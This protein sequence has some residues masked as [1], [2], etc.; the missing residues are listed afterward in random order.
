M[1][2]KIIAFLGALLCLNGS[3]LLAQNY[4]N[5]YNY[6]MINTANLDNVLNLTPATPSTTDIET[7]HIYT[8]LNASKSLYDHYMNLSATVNPATNTYPSYQYPA[9]NASQ[10]YVRNGLRFYKTTY[11]G[12]HLSPTQPDGNFRMIIIRPN[13]DSVRRCILYTNGALDYLNTSTYLIYPKL[14]DL[15]LRGYVVVFY[16]NNG[17][18]DFKGVGGKYYSNTA[19]YPCYMDNTC[20]NIFPPIFSGDDIVRKNY[21][22]SFQQGV[23]AYN[24]VKRAGNPYS[25]DTNQVFTYG[26]SAGAIT[27]LLLSYSRPGINFQSTIYVDFK[28]AGVRTLT[29]NG[30]QKISLFNSTA[31]YNVFIRTTAQVATAFPNDAGAGNFFPATGGRQVPALLFHGVNDNI[32]NMNGLIND[33]NNIT[34]GAIQ[35]KTGLTSGNIRSQIVVNCSGEH[36]F[37]T[38]PDVVI[39]NSTYSSDIDV[40]TQNTLSVKY[41]RM[42]YLLQQ[43]ND[44][45]YYVCGSFN[46]SSINPFPLPYTQLQNQFF[47]PTSSPY[48]ANSTVNNGHFTTSSCNDGGVTAN[49]PFRVAEPAN[50]SDILI[51]NNNNLNIFPNPGMH[52]LRTTYF[53]PFETDINI[54]IYNSMGAEVY[55]KQ[56]QHQIG[57]VEYT[58]DV[59]SFA[60]GAYFMILS[61][62]NETLSK[63]ITVAH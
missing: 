10:F 18:Q 25:I 23:A 53:T 54:K 33:P 5:G 44:L 57:R 45:N 62:K 34:D 21:Y 27:S 42:R 17:S 22:Y 46:F 39:P 19:A 38:N 14:I 41:Y 49:N 31:P 55:N 50:E 63:K 36:Y 15:A 16:E 59:S 51:E 28:N 6:Y 29:E 11:C 37:F 43:I 12:R 4:T 35:I 9:A 8:L 1:K 52:Q 20:N 61:N 24:F 40:F 60:N 32:I 26:T 13:D 30:F 3:V 7:R 47:I 48:V 2:K 58:I 56:Y